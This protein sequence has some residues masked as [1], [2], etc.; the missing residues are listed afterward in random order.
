MVTDPANDQTG[1]A[2]A[3]LSD[4]DIRAISLAEDYSSGGAQLVVT[5]K[6]ES[7]SATPPPNINWRTF[8]TGTH[9]DSTTTRY[10]VTATTA[11]PPAMTFKY[12]FV[13]TTPTG[14]TNLTVGDAD[15]GSFSAADGTLTV[16]VNLDKIR[17]PV[18]GTPNSTLTGPQ[19]DLSAGRQVINVNGVCTLLVGTGAAGGSNV[20]MDTTGNGVYTFVGAAACPNINPPPPPPGAA[21][22][23]INYYPPSGVA[24]DFGEPSIGANWRT[25]NIMFFGGFTPYALR[26]KFDDCTSPAKVRWDQTALRLAATPRVYGDP[27]LFTDKDTGRTFVSQLFG[28][29]PF[30]GMD[31][32]DD[33]GN[34]YLPSQGSGIGGGIDHQTVGGGPFHAPVPSGATYPHAV[35][36]CAQ[37]GL[38]SGGNG[39]ANCALSIDGG[40]TFGPAVP[41]YALGLNACSPLHGHIKVAPDGTAYLPNKKC[42]N[43]AGLVVSEDNGITWDARTIPGSTVGDS[44]ASIGIATDGTIFLG[45]EGSDGHP[46]IATSQDKG[47]TWINHTDVGIPVGVQNAVF[48][49][50]VAGDGNQRGPNTARAAFAFYGSSSPGDQDSPSFRGN[51]YLYIASTFDNGRTWTTVNATPND[52]MQRDGICTRGFQGCLVPRNLLDFF[53]A[54]VDKEGRVLVGYQDGCMGDCVTGGP[55]LNTTKG[56][57]ARQSGGP[58]M[59][60][61]YDRPEP[62]LPGAP[63]VTAS[64]NSGNTVVN[65]SWPAPDNGGSAITGYKVYRRAGATGSFVLLATATGNSY[66]DSTFD[67]SVQNFYRVT[68]VNGA[69]EGPACVEVS[70]TAPP[71]TACEMPGIKVIDD[72]FENGSDNDSGQNTPADSRVNVK[73]LHIA[74]PYLGDGIKKLIFTLKVGPSG[75]TGPPPSSQWYIVWNRLSPEPDFD[76]YYVAMKT[77]AS[78]VAS[79]EYGKFGVPLDTTVPP[80]IPPNVNPNANTPVK[81][82]DVD[83][84]FYDVANGVITI[85]LSNFKAE[86]IQA[87]QSLVDLNVRTFLARPD[88]GQRSQNN[89]SDITGN[90][91]YRLAGNASCQTVA[92]VALNSD[93]TLATTFASEPA[94]I[95]PGNML[96]KFAIVTSEPVSAPVTMALVSLSIVGVI[97]KL[98][99]RRKR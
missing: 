61:A 2:A 39:I 36:Y 17:K 86:N 37:D 19:V 87:G 89:A 99:W 33:D 56:V 35:Y 34:N 24:E 70:A 82:G 14:T 7:L 55:N 32:T 72:V 47:L 9:A 76:R 1:G 64:S 38:N 75:A 79:F 8:F 20:T 97:T 67:S 63:L 45:Y 62:G 22:R 74:E 94:R 21:P 42:G 60:A 16:R 40:H 65:L 48:P 68:A 51:W 95:V 52:P 77:N 27:I 44:D 84:G 58:R 10:F 80:A 69:G 29:T 23:Y 91:T 4:A 5:M 11:N 28:L 85:T 93:E 90:A 43:G 66:A 92:A 78:G 3:D 15:G 98:R 41:V 26:V 6:V 73:Q 46:R 25:G 57:I 31:Y 30:N 81:I 59:F 71:P 96:E 12:G 54:T 88:G 83:S 49:A 13:D 50:V 53:D 18:A